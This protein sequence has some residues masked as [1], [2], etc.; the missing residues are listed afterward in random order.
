MGHVQQL[1]GEVRRL[2]GRIEE[3]EQKLSALLKIKGSEKPESPKSEPP[4]A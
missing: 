1:Q 2:Q 3:L 4:E